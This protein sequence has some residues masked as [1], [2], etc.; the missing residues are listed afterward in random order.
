M[1]RVLKMCCTDCPCFDLMAASIRKS[2]PEIENRCAD[3]PCFDLLAASI[4]KSGPEIENRCTD[5][6][7]FDLLAASIRK[8]GPEIKNRC[9]KQ[10]ISS[11]SPSTHPSTRSSRVDDASCLGCFAWGGLNAGSAVAAK[12][13]ADAPGG[14]ISLCFC[15]RGCAAPAQKAATLNDLPPQNQ[16]K[17]PRSTS[18]HAQRA[19]PQAKNRTTMIKRQKVISL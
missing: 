19:V 16:P 9:R 8:S 11:T 18:R 13:G 4:R 3:C 10:P 15:R 2:G 17:P 1:E 14:G 12:A 6:P 5:C 7:C